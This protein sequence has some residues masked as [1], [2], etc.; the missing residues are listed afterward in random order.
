MKVVVIGTSFVGVVSASVYA[1]FGNEV[2][3]LDI[4]EKK[5]ASLKKSQ[6]PFY[7]PN[8]EELLVEQ[9]K[10]G[11][12]RF[13]TSYEEAIPGANVIMIAVGTPSAPDGQAD[14]KFVMAAS[15][16]VAEHLSPETTVVVKSTVPPGTLKKVIEVIKAKTNVNFYTASVPEFLKEGTAVHDTLNP[17]RVIIGATEPKAFEVLEELHKPLK[18]QIVKVTPESA[19]MAKYAANAY[20]AT[21]I[22]FANQIADLCDKNQANIQ[23]VINAI[24]F[25]PR[26]GTHYWYPGLGYGGSCFP[27]DV[28]ELAAYSRAV[29]EA[30]NLFNKINELNEQ[31]ITKLMDQFGKHVNGWKDKE[32]AVL[33]LA[34]KPHTDDMRE[35]PSA[36]IIPYLLEQGATVLGYDPKAQWPNPTD[37]F[38]QVDSI[39]KAVAKADVIMAVVEWPEIITFDYSQ[40]KAD[41]EQWFIDCRNQFDPDRVK[42]WGY[43]FISIGRP[44][45]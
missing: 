13:T 15:G 7:E 40:T 26:I 2:V 16:S 35:A 44:Q 17:D 42:N 1:S 12:L 5:I 25:D 23:E 32:V 41:R 31:R 43:D 30:N 19:Q 38:T 21:R 24:G 18:T 37:N 14:L 33:G 20:L 36:K 10:T 11:R 29:G 4:D 39:S 27:K 3:G 9:Q 22:T 28:K 34:F 8:L 45:A 6:V